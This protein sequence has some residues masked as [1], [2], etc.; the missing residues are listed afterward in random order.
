VVKRRLVVKRWIGGEEEI[1]GEEM[2]LLDNKKEQG[3]EVVVV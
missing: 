3:E 1:G 2:D